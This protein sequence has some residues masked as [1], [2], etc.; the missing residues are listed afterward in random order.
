M[1]PTHLMLL[2]ALAL[3]ITSTNLNGSG[4]VN[5]VPTLEVQG[6]TETPV[7]WP[8]FLTASAS[9][10]DGDPIEY[11]WHLLAKPEGS[12]TDLTSPEAATV[13][14]QPDLAGTY[15]LAITVSDGIHQTARETIISARH[16]GRPGNTRS[17]E[18]YNAQSLAQDLEDTTSAPEC[19]ET[20]PA[21]AV[22][23]Q[24]PALLVWSQPRR[25]IDGD[26][27][28]AIAS[29]NIYRASVPDDGT[30][31]TEY[32]HCLSHYATM[33]SPSGRPSP[34][35]TF[36]DRRPLTPPVCYAISTVPEGG[37]ES[38]FSNFVRSR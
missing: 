37:F 38:D 13:H 19:I 25:Y 14:L 28:Q 20:D 9:D 22:W 11:R 4:Y 33:E 26:R 30:P 24:E 8:V 1:P 29:F 10:H 7:G 17:P 16:N 21:A 27:L 18:P 2:T 35:Q 32:R 23:V 6:V 31:C 12:G 15:R 34:R 36:V 3:T 5:Y